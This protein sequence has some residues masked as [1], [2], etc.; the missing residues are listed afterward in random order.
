MRIAI[1]NKQAAATIAKSEEQRGGMFF[2]REGEAGKAVTNWSPLENPGV[3]KCGG[4][5][6]AELFLGRRGGGLW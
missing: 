5:S 3:R 2:R 4:F 6:L 1:R